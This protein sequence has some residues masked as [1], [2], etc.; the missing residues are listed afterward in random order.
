VAFLYTGQGSQWRGMGREL[1][2]GEP[3]FREVLDRCEGVVRE[4]R[5][6]SLLSVLFGE[7]EGLDGTEWAQPALYAIECGLTALWG[8]VGVR[9][10]AVFGHSVGEVAAAAAAGVF[11]VEEGMRFAA[12]RGALMGSLPSGGA[13]GA[14]FAPEERVRAALSGS[15]SLAAEN[16]AH[17]V[18]SGPEEEVAGLLEEFAGSGVRVER[19]VVSHAFHSALLDPVLADLEGAVPAVSAP[20]VP[21]VS[22]VSGRLLEGAPEPAYWSR[23]AREPVRFGTALGTMAEL[24]VGVLVEIG[25]RAVLGPMAALSWPGGGAPVVVSSLRK[26]GGG[27]FVAAVAGV[28]EAGV[29]V[30]FAGLFAGERRRRVSLPT[31]PFQRER[32]WVEPPGRRH[33][34]AGHPLLGTRL[35]LRRGGTAFEIELGAGGRSWLSD[36][37]VFGEV[38]A[39]GALY[40]AQV[41][42]ALGELGRSPSGSLAAVQLHR[43]LVLSD[44]GRSVQ[45]LL[46]S[47]GRFEVASRAAGAEWE[48]HAEGGVGAAAD[49]G[50]R[51]ELEEL[52]EGLSPLPAD[53][54]YAR[55]AACGIGHGPTF[56]VLGEVWAGA[57]E[58]LGEVAL[59]AGSGIA[60]TASQP[61]LLDGCFQALYGVSELGEGKG[62]WLPI[63]W[64]RLWLAG[65]LPERLWCRARLG[66]GSGETRTA[67]LEFYAPGGEAL[68]SVTGF[69]L[70]RGSRAAL[71]GARMDDLVYEPVWR[72]GRPVGLSPADFLSGPEA[73]ASGLEPVDGHLSAEGL[74]REG[75]AALGGELERESLWFTLRALDELGWE[76]RTGERFE[77]EELRRRLKV[78]GEHR[79]L[80]G[81][82]LRLLE[83]AGLVRGDPAGGWLVAGV[84]ADPLPG[85][86]APDGPPGTVEQGLL[87]RCGAS[88]AEV[89]RGRVDPLELLFGGE[90]GAAELYR[91]AGVLRAVNRLVADAVG[92]A[93]GELPAGR[94]LRVLEVGAG[95]GATTAAVL[96]ALPAERTDYE[97][98]D[99]SAGF[100]AEAE[101]RFGA[102]GA[103]F[104]SR[105]LDI[106][107]DPVEQ[108]FDGHG[109]DVVLAANVLHTTRD[110]QE[111]LANCRRLLA[112]S[113][114]LL[115]VEG[116]AAAGWLDL[117][118]G[119]LPGWWRFADGY[120][121]DSALVGPEVWR[122]A[123]EEAGY[124]EVS[125]VGEESGQA[126]ILARGPAA[127]EEAP[128]LFVLAGEGAF[129]EA[130]GEELRKRRQT[131]LRG[132]AAGG[133]EEWRSFFGS[134]PGEVPLRGVA[135]LAGVRGDG[136]GLSAGEL[137]EELEAVGSGAL[138]LVQGLVDAGVRPSSGLWFVTRGGQVVERERSGALSGAML[139]GFGSVVALEEEDLKPRLVDLDPE[140]APAA[141]ALADELLH[142]DPETRVARRGADRLVARLRRAAR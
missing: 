107:R 127:V 104:R 16:G 86:V 115:A 82:L 58:A 12:R 2:G 111:T 30:S 128:G 121:S 123:L 98:T 89:L 79:R 48:L 50:A 54:V 71:L 132:P 14:V 33:A 41:F 67:E 10:D 73:V 105:A 87:R 15:V 3:V 53:R 1:Y 90:P 139:W 43:P 131:V 5:G 102:G 11:D 35:D 6:V 34:E 80:F 137:G 118:F 133:R 126:V 75:L 7:E 78:T 70:K 134:L 138:S 119:L 112:P 27:D 28:Y 52:R 32:Y 74:D 97:F 129:A 24:G 136:S 21:L 49:A 29:D 120:R 38:V 109:Y 26:R 36:H 46:D 141:G 8:S 92:A 142:P 108:G 135:H 25:P 77:T 69:T 55:L 13:M 130:V 63:G 56:R 44:R 117:T 110:L 51:V 47:E 91:D 103:A 88:L 125:F 66:K 106:E 61:V 64:D 68:G 85:A 96:A 60:G 20:A 37:R 114:L 18:V 4:E 84:A 76:R 116:T 124:G 94:R 40:A 39:P 81:R 45:V 95:T 101:R 122:R 62:A 99:I 42:A 113:G 140:G 23:Q 57:E 83:E 9:P 65:P 100:F 72:E 93:A 17:C 59:P 31:Y 22:D 19:L